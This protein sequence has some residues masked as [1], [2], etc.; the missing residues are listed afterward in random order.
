ML[1]LQRLY[2]RS[3]P[4]TQPLALR[5]NFAWTL[6]G[7]VVYALSQWG[8]T[9]VLAKFGSPEMLGRF[10]LGLAITAP[11]ILF[12]GLALRP[13]QATDV[14]KV[15]RFEDYLGL[16]LATTV[17]ALLIITLIAVVGGYDEDTV[18]VILLIGLAK[19]FEAV[20]DIFYGLFQ[21]HE[22]MDRVAISMIIRGPLS[23]MALAVAVLVT[24]QVWAGA[25]ALAFTWA[26]VLVFY[27]IPNGKAILQ[28][29][30]GWCKGQLFRRWSV[31]LRLFWLSLPLGFTMMLISLNTNIPRYFIEHYW[32]QRELGFFAA[33]AYLMVAGTT[34][35]NALGQSASPRLA[36]YYARGD[37]RKFVHLLLR[38]LAMGLMLGFSG[39]L[40]SLL[41]GREILTLL[42]HEEYAEWNSVLVW[43]M[44]S[45]ALSYIASFLGYAMT[46]AHCF[47]I[48]PVIFGAVALAN[49]LSCLALV[50]RYGLLGAAWALGVAHS[51]QILASMASVMIALWRSPYCKPSQELLVY[52]LE[53]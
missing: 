10:A 25:A 3:E 13:V 33:I 27:D 48:Q 14:R 29:G 8:M 40:L 17:I 15:Y 1:S 52:E 28:H 9:V 18:W 32:G 11:V 38:L 6:T 37:R 26:L 36:K 34:V 5:T 19:A 51:L 21:Q 47:V 7:N 42:Y 2:A 44:V 41:A 31:R 49:G 23:L 50:P 35:V 16:R 12:A 4:A 39:I 30:L 22:R 43:V 46:A 20:S 53:R 24:R 45:A